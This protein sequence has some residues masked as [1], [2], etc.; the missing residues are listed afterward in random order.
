MKL[1]MVAS[2]EGKNSPILSTSDVKKNLPEKSHWR[3]NKIDKFARLPVWPVLNGVFIFFL[4]KVFGNE[5]ASKVEDSIGGRVCPNFFNPPEST[6]PFIMLVHHVHAFSLLDP[7]RYIQRTF[8]PEGFPAHPHRGFIT[9]TYCMSGGMVH[10]DSLGVK[11][12]YGAEPRHNGKHTQ[13]LT[14]GAGILHEEMWDVSSNLSDRQE[15]Y[16]LWLNLPAKYKMCNPSVHLLGGEE[17]TP[18]VTESSTETGT[19]ETIV[20][21]GEHNGKQAR[22]SQ[23]GEVENTFIPNVTILHVKMRAGST[24]THE[25][26]PSHDNLIIYIRKGSVM[27]KDTEIKTHHIAY[28]SPPISYNN[29]SGN[30]YISIKTAPDGDEADFLFLSGESLKEPVSAQGSMVMNYPDEINVAYNDWQNFKMGARSWD[31]KISDEEWIELTKQFPSQY[32]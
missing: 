23:G 8:F 11:Q 31:H 17:E 16:Q 32:R 14:A 1:H 25:F 18:T 4:S 20:I 28:L 7:V 24:F 22:F 29:D 5:I 9:V 3:M 21:C 13:W 6:S 19:T 10:R 26:P 15:L 30:S 12:T 27:I 2:G